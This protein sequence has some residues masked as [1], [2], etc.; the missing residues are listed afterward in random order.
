MYEMGDRDRGSSWKRHSTDR[1]KQTQ[2]QRGVCEIIGGWRGGEIALY[3]SSN[4]LIVK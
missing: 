4:R 3:L 2:T 1:E